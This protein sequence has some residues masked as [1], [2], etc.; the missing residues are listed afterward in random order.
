MGDDL[1]DLFLVEP[2]CPQRVDVG[3]LYSRPSLDYFDG[4]LK[5]CGR[6]FFPFNCLKGKNCRF[7]DGSCRS[8]ISCAT[9]RP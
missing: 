7:G 1:D 2:C 6:A 5:G 8:D 9:R 4:E 3:R